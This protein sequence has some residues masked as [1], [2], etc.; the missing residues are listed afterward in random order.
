MEH[1]KDVEREHDELLAAEETKRKAEGDEEH[2]RDDER[3]PGAFFRKLVQ[4]EKPNTVS[5]IMEVEVNEQR[6]RWKRFTTESRTRNSWSGAAGRREE[7]DYMVET[8]ET[9][10]VGSWQKATTRAGKTTTKTKRVDRM[11]V[12]DQGH[13]FVGCR[14]VLRD[15]KP[16]HAGPRDD[17]CA[18]MHPLE[19]NKALCADAAGTR[20]A[21]RDRGELEVKL[22]AT[23]PPSL[24]ITKTNLD[25][26]KVDLNEGC[27]ETQQEWIEL[28]QHSVDIQT[29]PDQ[30]R[31]R[32]SSSVDLSRQSAS[33]PGMTT[34]CSQRQM[35]R[36]SGVWQRRCTM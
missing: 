2:G 11:K 13:E 34:G 30:A 15:F 17:L 1:P 22:M 7:M 8:L 10:E 14:I 26:K 32:K 23:T 33:T 24:S 3:K 6:L 19:T 5:E 12:D 20:R 27:G 36:C 31:S 4:D 21:G 25:E 16:R 9:L 29:T 28:P 18:A 35:R